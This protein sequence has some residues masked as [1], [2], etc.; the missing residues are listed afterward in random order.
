MLDQDELTRLRIRGASAYHTIKH[1]DVICHI[2]CG[3]VDFETKCSLIDY[4]Y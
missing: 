1:V 4:R 3:I 2:V